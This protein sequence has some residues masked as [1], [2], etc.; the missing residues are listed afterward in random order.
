MSWG[1]S[2][3]NIL[4]V[5]AVLCVAAIASMAIP[6]SIS[7]IGVRDTIIMIFLELLFTSNNLTKNTISAAAINLSI[8]QTFMNVLLPGLLGGL[9][10]LLTSKTFKLRKELEEKPTLH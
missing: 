8:L 7:G 1:T 2:L 5:I 3:Q 10:I 4:I 6:I 9:L